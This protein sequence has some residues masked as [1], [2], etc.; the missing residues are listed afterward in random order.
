MKYRIIWGVSVALAASITFLFYWSNYINRA[1]FTTGVYY[2]FL[3]L[4]TYVMAELIYS[5]VVKLEQR[6]ITKPS[7]VQISKVETE[8]EPRLAERTPYPGFQ[9]RT[10]L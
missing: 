4:F 2:L 9:E 3:F 6:F 10:K 5:E 1:N 8:P 7:P